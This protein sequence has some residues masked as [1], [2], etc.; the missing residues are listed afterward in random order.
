MLLQGRLSFMLKTYSNVPT[1]L[2]VCDPLNLSEAPRTRT[3]L[4]RLAGLS[5]SM[6]AGEILNEINKFSYV[7]DGCRLL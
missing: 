1:L 6:I 5:V 4:L 3:L 2:S 7:G